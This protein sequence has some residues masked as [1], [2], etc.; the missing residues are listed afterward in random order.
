MCYFASRQEL[1]FYL[2]VSVMSEMKTRIAPSRM[3]LP[4]RRPIVAF[5][6]RERVQNAVRRVNRWFKR[7][8]D[9]NDPTSHEVIP[10]ERRRVIL[11]VRTRG[12][13]KLQVLATPSPLLTST[14]GRCESEEVFE[15]VLGSP[16]VGI[17][18]AGSDVDPAS[19]E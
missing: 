1:H 11:R 10:E 8:D 18:S 13:K 12:S 9:L 17:Q 5:S 3:T 14:A 7:R 19:A 4:S 6:G 15:D 2:I 16:G